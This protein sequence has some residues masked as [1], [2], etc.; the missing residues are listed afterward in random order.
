MN[1]V[2]I[3]PIMKNLILVCILTHFAT[4]LFA[5]G[6]CA[7]AINLGTIS[8]TNTCATY[9]VNTAGSSSCIA[10]GPGNG[11]IMYVRFCTNA[12]NTC[13]NFGL[14]A[15]TS[16]GGLEM[17]IYNS[18]ACG[19]FA[20]NAGNGCG[21]VSPAALSTTGMALAASTCYTAKIWVKNSGTVTLCA[22]AVAPAVN[23]ACTGAMGIGIAPTATNNNPEC[24][25]S[26]AATDPAPADFCAGSLENTAWYTFTTLSTC[27][28][29][30][31]VVVTISGIVCVGGGSG[32]QIG[33]FTGAC[34]SLTNLGCSSGS[35]GTVTTTIL[36]LSPNQTVTIG[37]DGNAGAN[38][39]FNISATNTIVPL[40]I[41]LVSFSAVQ[42]RD[43]VTIDWTTASETNNNYYTIEKSYD[44]I[45]FLPLEN[46]EGQGTTNSFTTYN[47][48]DYNLRGGLNYYR[49][50]QTDFDGKFTYSDTRAV[51]ISEDDAALNFTIVPNPSDALSYT[52]L[53][54]NKKISEAI[55][56]TICDINAKIMHESLVEVDGTTVDLNHQLKSGIY[57]VRVVSE[58]SV[59]TKRLVI[60]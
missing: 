37:L 43:Y 50:K 24:L 16:S 38:C 8:A 14:T 52:S 45:D 42:L 2:P 28:F 47:R 44:G 53:I 60:R 41:S 32:F 19:A 34:G 27:T 12:S 10:G 5:Q 22:Q 59:I 21:L 54:L 29:P 49:L 9:N 31:T 7:T 1:I 17:I 20:T 25:F 48:K 51:I 35:G 15:G 33:Y 18:T 46:I 30:C 11:S 36:N 56:V 13:I 55:T 57:I 4:N 3:K 23:D 39:S 40:P 58:G 6:T 26:P